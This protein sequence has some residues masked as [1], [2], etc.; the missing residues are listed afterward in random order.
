MTTTEELVT[1]DDGVRLRT[2]TLGSPKPD[3][4]PIVCVHGDADDTVPVAQSERF[5]AAAR[6]AGDPARTMII[7]GGDHFGVI[8]PGEPGWAACAQAVEELAGAS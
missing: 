8:T 7:P 4:P 1:L 3:M 6:A 5:V 2:W